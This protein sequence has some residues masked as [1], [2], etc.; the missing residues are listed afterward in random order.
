MSVSRDGDGALCACTLIAMMVNFDGSSAIVDAACIATPCD[1]LLFSLSQEI[2]NSS[3]SVGCL[4]FQVVFSI[5]FNALSKLVYCS[6]NLLF[7]SM[8]LSN[9]SFSLITSCLLPLICAS[10]CCF[11][12]TSSFLGKIK[13]FS[14][15][16]WIQALKVSFSITRGRWVQVLSH[17]ADGIN[18]SSLNVVSSSN[19]S[20]RHI[21]SS[22]VKMLG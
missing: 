9:N 7:R 3:L 8:E 21:L 2:L 22:S 17:C 5:M 4:R 12:I 1:V 14:M 16:T 13:R 19:N 6:L 15:L 10:K 11:T 18:G 20:V